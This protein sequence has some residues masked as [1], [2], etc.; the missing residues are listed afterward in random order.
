[1]KTLGIIS[2]IVAS[3]GII[4]AWAEMGETTANLDS[5]LGYGFFAFLVAGMLLAIGIVSLK[6]K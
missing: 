3:F 1:M 4:F 2:I 5:M 6:H